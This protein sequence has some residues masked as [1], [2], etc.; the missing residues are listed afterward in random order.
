M[1]SLVTRL[2]SVVD[3]LRRKVSNR[4]P[5]HRGRNAARPAYRLEIEPL[6]HRLV[7][8]HFATGFSP[9]ASVSRIPN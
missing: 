6:E 5:A 3:S 2:A 4:P 9:S 7:P 8:T 1:K